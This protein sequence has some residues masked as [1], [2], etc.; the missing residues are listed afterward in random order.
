MH[1]A[2][3]EPRIKAAA[4]SCYVTSLPMRMYNRIF[5]DPDSD[6]EQDLYRNGFERRRQRR[7]DAHDVSKAGLRGSGRSRFLSD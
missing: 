7:P 6:P 2:A 3:L 5:K 1:I 4:I